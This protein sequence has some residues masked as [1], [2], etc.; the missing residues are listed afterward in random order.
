M[1][2]KSNQP[3][4]VEAITLEAKKLADAVLEEKTKTDHQTAEDTTQQ[5]FDLAQAVS[6]LALV[7]TTQQETIGK[8]KTHLREKHAIPSSKIYGMI[9]AHQV[10]LKGL[11]VTMNKEL[12]ETL[13]NGLKDMND[14]TV[15]GM[16]VPDGIPKAYIDS[17][18]EGFDEVVKTLKD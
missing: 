17:L 5:L 6:S 13:I 14:G 10:V 16:D 11:K 8:L 4:D 2:E 12:R 15:Q 1:E 9:L 18:K 3:V 7:A